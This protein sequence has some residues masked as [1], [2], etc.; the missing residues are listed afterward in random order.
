MLK[1]LNANYPI[2]RVKINFKF[3]R[4]IIVETKIFVLNDKSNRVLL[5]V[6]LIKILKKVFSCDEKICSNITSEFLKID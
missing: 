3:K 5:K 4:A 1:F 2:S 6:E